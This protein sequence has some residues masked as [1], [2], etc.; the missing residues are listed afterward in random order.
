MHAFAVE[1]GDED[2]DEESVVMIQTTLRA[3]AG[4]VVMDAENKYL[5][6]MHATA[7][8]YFRNSDNTSTILEDL[9]RTERTYL[10]LKQLRNGPCNSVDAMIDRSKKLPFLDYAAQNWGRH[11]SNSD[12]D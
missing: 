10:C 1:P 12:F 2:I 5:I 4:L 6:L 11:A 7:Y 3:S 8:E 9:A